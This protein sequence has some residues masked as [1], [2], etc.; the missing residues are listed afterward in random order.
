[1]KGVRSSLP[2]DVSP[3]KY[4]R[5]KCTYTPPLPGGFLLYVHWSR[6]LVPGCPHKVTVTSKGDV[7]KVTVS[8]EGLRGGIAGHELKVFVDT[9]EAGPGEITATCSSHRQGAQVSIQQN[10][11]YHYTLRILPTS[12]DKHLLQIKYDDQYVPGSPFVLRIGEPP[13]PSRVKV[14]GPG[15]EDGVLYTFESTFLVDTH[16]AGAGQLAVRVR[17]PRESFK[18]DMHQDNQNERTIKCKYSP[19]EPGNYVINVRWSGDHVPGSPFNVT[20][21]DHLEELDAILKQKGIS[22]TNGSMWREEI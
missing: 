6:M 10:E 15:V 2:V 16:G 1:M 9:K 8:G 19:T 7:T 21:V 5:Y 12:V 14:F 13:D 18:V 17:G 3:M 4:D 22:K 20:I 11:A